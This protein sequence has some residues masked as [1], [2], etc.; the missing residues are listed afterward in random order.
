MARPARVGRAAVARGP[1][2]VGRVEEV[3]VHR[4]CWWARIA[5]VRNTAGYINSLFLV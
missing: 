1:R 5:I 3:A 4:R 2:R